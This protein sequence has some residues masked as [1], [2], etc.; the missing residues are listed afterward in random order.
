MGQT[1]ILVYEPSFRRVEARL[2][3]SAGQAAF[4]VMDANGEV[5]LNGALV[6]PAA[7]A[8]Q[9]GWFDHE[10]MLSGL[11]SSFAGLLLKSPALVWVQSAAAGFEQPV[12]AKFVGKGARLTTNHSQAIPMADYVLWGVLDA[13]Q[14]GPDRRTAQAERQWARLRFREVL[15][16][17]WLI[18]GFGAIGQEIARRAKAFGARITGVRRSGGAHPL[19]DAIAGLDALPQLLP[20]N[21]VVV[22]C[23]PESAQTRG[24]ANAAF[25]ERMKPGSVIVNIGRGGLLDEAALVAALERDA[26][27]HA[28]LDVFQTEP[29]PVESPL[30]AH[31]KVTLTAHAS[32][33]TVGFRSRADALFLENLDRYLTGQPLR[34]EVSAEEVLAG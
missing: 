26:P 7:V 2:P 3:A 16:S 5:R 10:V 32:P 11:V 34:N 28:L 31:P 20:Q 27:G 12:F 23:L 19:A 1:R 4:M 8:A 22:L 33:I 15:D 29:L 24:L 13:F 17:Q 9:I 14:R 25:F 30:W 6:D 21:D 18:I